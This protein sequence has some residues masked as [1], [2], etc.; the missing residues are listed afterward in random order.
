MG[1]A[2][3]LGGGQDRAKKAHSGR[4]QLTSPSAKPARGLAPTLVRVYF[5][6]PRRLRATDLSGRLAGWEMKRTPGRYGGRVLGSVPRA[7]RYRG[8]TGGPGKRCP[9]GCGPPGLLMTTS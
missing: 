3:Q 4:C 6:T 7:D 2:P 8:V 1:D 5:R 9:E